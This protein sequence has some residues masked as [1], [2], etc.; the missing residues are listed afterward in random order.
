MSWWFLNQDIRPNEALFLGEVYFSHGGLSKQLG[1]LAALFPPDALGFGFP[2][3]SAPYM[4]C[5]LPYHHKA[6][7]ELTVQKR[8]FS[9]LRDN[10]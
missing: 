8:A 2:L 3:I 9:E 1:W 6:W 4:V 5:G 7:K 10:S